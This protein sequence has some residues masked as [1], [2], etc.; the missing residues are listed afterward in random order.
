MEK[1]HSTSHESF[2]SMLPRNGQERR[3]WDAWK[4][5]F[6]SREIILNFVPT[7]KKVSIKSRKGAS[8]ERKQRLHQRVSE[9]PDFPPTPTPT[10]RITQWLGTLKPLFPLCC[11]PGIELTLTL[12]KESG[13]DF[14]IHI[15]WLYGLFGCFEVSLKS[16]SEA[17]ER[18]G[19]CQIAQVLPTKT[20]W[21][22]YCDAEQ[23]YALRRKKSSEW[24]GQW[25]TVG[26]TN[27]SQPL[28]L[29]EDPQYQ[30]KTDFEG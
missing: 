17:L 16:S 24:A 4:F 9:A 6:R 15:S 1:L 19:G 21:K 10:P 8:E 11:H 22:D 12:R 27:C 20:T 26:R 13:A 29:P 30:R 14:S 18:E 5:I 7:A 2:S 28:N 25:I 23:D 3:A